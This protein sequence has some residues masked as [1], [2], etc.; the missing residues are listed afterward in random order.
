[1]PPRPPHRRRSL[2]HGQASL[3]WLAV[4]A[5]VASLLALGAGLAQAD[6]VGR[7]VTREMAR[8]LCLVSGGD[9][10]R[11]QEPCVEA[12][13]TDRS[14]WKVGVSYFRLGADR[15]ALVERRSDGT[16]AVSVGHGLS[17]GLEAEY[18]FSAKAKVAGLDVLAGGTV[19][20]SILAKLEGTRTWIVG[21]EAEA[22][23]ILSAGGA[24][25]SPDLSSSKGGTTASA[26]ASLG[27]EVEGV[28]DAEVKAAEGA[29]TFDQEAGAIT[30]HRTGRRTIYV[31]AQASGSA[32]LLGGVLGAAASDAVETY[33]VELAPDGRPL[34]LQITA[35]G[36][37]G[38]SR[39]LPSV[40]QPVVGRLGAPG[41]DQY[42]VTA[43]LDL[44]DPTA[45][46]AASALIDGISHHRGRAEP[47]AELRRLIASTGTVEARILDTKKDSDEQGIDVTSG[48]HV[49]NINH[50]IE[51]REQRLLAAASRGLDGQWI[52]REDCVRPT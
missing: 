8:A 24:S 46:D 12:S 41:A 26:G 16:Y 38:T 7:R 50:A 4:V 36:A 28:E 2:E 20:A 39:D 15:F 5:L 42:E 47:S 21:S 11:D 13:N 43:T 25:R 22:Q 3:E 29:V 23:A 34:V 33:S 52:A 51:H 37:Y 27:A 9:C 18:G 14:S 44:S 1:M 6:G 35:T 17:A 48:T 45:R 49:V 19:T 31:D 10:R 30:D 40:V 32:S